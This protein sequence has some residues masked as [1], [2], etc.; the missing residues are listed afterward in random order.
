M[1]ALFDWPLTFRLALLPSPHISR[2][3][4]EQRRLENAG[5]KDFRE[6]SEIPLCWKTYSKSKREKEMITCGLNPR[7]VC[8]DDTSVGDDADVDPET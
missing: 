4:I 3:L 6:I 2:D 1:F 5:R 7:M 8:S